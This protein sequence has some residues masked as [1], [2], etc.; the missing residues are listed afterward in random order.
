MIITIERYDNAMEACSRAL[1][2]VALLREVDDLARICGTNVATTP[3]SLLAGKESPLCVFDIDDTLLRNDSSIIQEVFMLYERLRQ[4]GARLFL[5]TARKSTMHAFTVK[6]LKGAGIVFEEDRLFI[7]PDEFRTSMP[8]VSEWKALMRRNIAMRHGAP[9]ML[10]VGDQWGDMVPI[11][12][13]GDI[14]LL[15]HTYGTRH[16]AWIVLQPQS[17]Y[18]LDNEGE[19]CVGL[20]LKA[21]D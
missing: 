14:E 3:E 12:N 5:V 2:S 19:T 6:E 20:K 8:K 7:C 4:L 9:I 15:D 18:F 13:D 11:S 21:D 1:L 17:G 10:S 16:T